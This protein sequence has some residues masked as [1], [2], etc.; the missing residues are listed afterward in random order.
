MFDTVGRGRISV[1]SGL[2]LWEQHSRI[3]EAQGW[4][5][6]LQPVDGSMSSR[7]QCGSG[8]HAK[9]RCL[10]QQKRGLHV[11]HDNDLCSERADIPDLNAAHAE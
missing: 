3:Q 5:V 2:Q 7:S 4:R 1:M 8:L 10:N 11:V 9:V 6:C